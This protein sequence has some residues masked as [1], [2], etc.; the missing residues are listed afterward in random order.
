MVAVLDESL[1]G[2]ALAHAE[3]AV[4]IFD[5][6]RRFLAVNDRYLELTGYSHDDMDDLRAGENLALS[7]FEENEFIAK[8]T[9]AISAGEADVI[10]RSGKPLAVEYVV[11]PTRLEKQRLF[12][13][14]MWPLVDDG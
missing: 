14:L 3:A 13:G 6:D 4:A 7:P 11:I 9:A 10:Q 2:G 8:I 1:L 5:E 12:I